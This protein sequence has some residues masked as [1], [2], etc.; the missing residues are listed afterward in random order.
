LPHLSGE[1]SAQAELK[2]LAPQAGRATG[3]WFRK[4]QHA[5]HKKTEQGSEK[6]EAQ[7]AQARS[8]RD[9]GGRERSGFKIPVNFEGLE[10]ALYS[11][12]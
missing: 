5:S 3:A 4:C 9:L 11:S 2:R 6:K 12:P 10:C 8:P 1:D 7:E